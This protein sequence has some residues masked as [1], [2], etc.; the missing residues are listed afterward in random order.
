ML[1]QEG[2][3]LTVLVLQQQ[4]VQVAL[5]I[6]EGGGLRQEGVLLTV[7]VLQQQTVQVTLWI[8][9]V[10]SDRRAST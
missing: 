10:C 8:S 9:E 6:S 3:H 2:V 5:W 4:T 7:L 1:R